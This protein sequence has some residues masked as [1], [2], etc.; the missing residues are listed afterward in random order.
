MLEGEGAGVFYRGAGIFHEF[1]HNLFCQE[2][3]VRPTSACVTSEWGMKYGVLSNLARIYE[4]LVRKCFNF[5][6]SVLIM[7]IY[8]STPGVAERLQNKLFK[9]QKQPLEVLCVERFLRNLTKFT[10][11]HLRQSLFFNKAF[12][13]IKKESLAQVLS[14]EFC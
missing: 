2:N 6:L 4:F 8:Y 5:L 9:R 1:S 3:S 11:K 7:C 10:A 14:C 12:N 13:F